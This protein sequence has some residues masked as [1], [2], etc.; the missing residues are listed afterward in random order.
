ME[1]AVVEL[2]ELCT[3]RTSRPALGLAKIEDVRGALIVS[4]GMHPVVVPATTP[5]A[6]AYR[7]PWCGAVVDGCTAAE[8]S[9]LRD[10]AKESTASGLVTVY[11][12]EGAEF[13]CF[14]FE[15]GDEVAR[16]V[17]LGLGERNVLAA[18]AGRVEAL[19]TGSGFKEVGETSDVVV[20]A[21]R[22]TDLRSIDGVLADDADVTC[23][24][25]ERR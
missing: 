10:R 23:C 13:T 14:V 2:D 6:R 24:S 17:R 20:M 5:G 4:T 3:T 8:Q 22:H 19:V 25:S 12:V 1:A 15:S 21:T 9:S 11:A 16:E 7:A 18:A